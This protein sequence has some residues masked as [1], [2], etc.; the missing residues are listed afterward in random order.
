[1]LSIIQRATL[2]AAGTPHVDAQLRKFGFLLKL[3]FHPQESEMA[4]GKGG[5]IPY[6]A[7]VNTTATNWLGSLRYGWVGL[8]WA[9]LHRLSSMDADGKS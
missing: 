1:M 8:C 7:I 4:G 3:S 9:E 5:K 6:P 2:S